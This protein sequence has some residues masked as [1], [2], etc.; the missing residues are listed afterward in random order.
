MLANIVEIAIWC[1]VLG[2]ASI[3]VSF[4]VTSSPIIV[5]VGN[6][7]GSLLSALFVIY[8]GD[9]I[10]NK[11]EEERLA[12]KRFT[13]KIVT[14]FEEGDNNKKVQKV[15][16]LI[17]KHGL[18][19]FSL[20]CPIFPGVLVSTVAV[21]VLNLDKKIYKKWMSVGVVLV[22]GFYVFSYWFVFVRK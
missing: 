21:Y 22:S 13:K 3:P 5:W 18:K 17:N 4:T 20:V 12:K 2:G 10:T 15:R 16:I 14:V 6:A 11:Q 7:L 19:L 9:R 1:I 8:I